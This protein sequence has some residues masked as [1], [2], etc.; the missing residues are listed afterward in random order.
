VRIEFEYRWP[1]L[2]HIEED[3]HIRYR[4]EHDLGVDEATR[5]TADL[6]D[7]VSIH[8][9]VSVAP[10]RVSLFSTHRTGP[11]AGQG[12]P[13]TSP[14]DLVRPLIHSQR[15]PEERDEL[16]FAAHQHPRG[17]EG[18]FREWHLVAERYRRVVAIVSALYYAP[19]RYR[20]PELLLAATMAETLHRLSDFPQQT[21]REDMDSWNRLLDVAPKDLYE[22]LSSFLSEQA[23]PSLRRR[24]KDIVRALGELG[25]ELVRNVPEY[26]LRLNR[27]R[28]SAVHHGQTND[29]SGAHMYQLAAVTRLV[30]ELY[31]MREAGFDLDAGADRIQTLARFRR[32]ARLKLD[33]PP[34][35]I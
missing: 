24:L 14:L 19:Q 1:S 4:F 26:E 5:Y 27:W 34:L 17:V 6:R 21:E 30:V 33:W 28:N 29:L 35:A 11:N 25:K 8:S 12:D 3:I 31:L 13:S 15:D 22:W 23:E 32:A 16:L 18:L 10:D 9:G 20:N 7:L 2:G